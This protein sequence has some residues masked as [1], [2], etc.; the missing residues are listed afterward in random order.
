MYALVVGVFVYK[1]LTLQ[2]IYNALF[3]AMKSS[4]AVMFLCTCATFFGWLL[5]YLGT[6]N[7]IINFLTSAISNKYVMFLIIGLIV[8]VRCQKSKQSQTQRP[9]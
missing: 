8:F 2:K 3:N 1:E 9:R 4:V 5:T 6:T 7:H